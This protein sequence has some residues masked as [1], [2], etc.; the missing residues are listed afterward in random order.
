MF[1]ELAKTY[2][3]T[4][5]EYERG[6]KLLREFRV[7]VKHSSTFSEL[8]ENFFLDLDD[9]DCQLLDSAGELVEHPG[10]RE[11]QLSRKELS[12][13]AALLRSHGSG[14][15]GGSADPHGLHSK[16][17]TEAFEEFLAE[18]RHGWK[19]TNGSEGQYRE[20]VF[21]LFLELNGDLET[22]KINKTHATAF[23]TAVLSLPKNRHKMPEYRRLKISD[24]MKL[25]I[26]RDKQLSITTKRNYLRRLS[27]F[28]HWLEDHDYSQPNLYAPLK[29]PS[30]KKV[31][32]ASEE[33]AQYTDAELTKLFNSDDYT[34]GLHRHSFQYWVP[35]IGLFTGAREN[36]ICQL[37]TS[38]IRQE[39]ETGI[40]VFDFNENEPEK[41]R[42]SL[43]RPFHARTFPIHKQLIALGI[44]E[45]ADYQRKR[46]E[47]RLF[48]ELPYHDKNKYAN[49][50]QRWYNTTYE[51]KCGLTGRT[52]FHSLR[53]TT[54]NYLKK[55]LKLDTNSF[56]DWIGQTASGTESD[57]RYVKRLTLQEFHK[58]YRK[59]AFDCIDFSNLRSWRAQAFHREATGAMSRT[60]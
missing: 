13:L 30:L 38:D 20:E 14:K 60:R 17:V 4:E 51:K 34:Q 8:E 41:T 22:A 21:P 25:S 46:G 48:P 47:Q 32:R 43:K 49:K 9:D 56:V 3:E 23:V 2:F 12:R 28:L 52:S 26:P 44:L 57:R 33:R 7:A 15:T 58:I 31:A 27:S 54:I 10:R 45:F 42:K 36:E 40:W 59:L 37:F 39:E 18:K 11:A 55:Q 1:D 35:L 53:H 29:S 19:P 6:I 50:M 16:P 24:L 5:A